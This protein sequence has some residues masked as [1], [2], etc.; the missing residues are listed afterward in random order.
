M[1]PGMPPGEAPAT[2][3]SATPA[4]SL[5]PAT[6]S[7]TSRAGLLTEGPLTGELDVLRARVAQLETQL[8]LSE[9]ERMPGS[10]S[11]GGPAPPLPPNRPASCPS[12]A[13][14]DPNSGEAYAMRELAEVRDRMAAVEG[15]LSRLLALAEPPGRPSAAECAFDGA[16]AQAGAPTAGTAGVLRGA[17]D[18]DELEVT[19]S[20]GSG[21]DSRCERQCGSPASCSSEAAAGWA[22]PAVAWGAQRA[23]AWLLPGVPQAGPLC[24]AAEEDTAS[25]SGDTAPLLKA[26]NTPPSP[27]RRSSQDTPG[28]SA[29]SAGVEFRSTEIEAEYGDKGV[30]SAAR[31]ALAAGLKNPFLRGSNN[32]LEKIKVGRPPWPP[33]LALAA[34]AALTF[35]SAAP[36]PAESGRRVNGASLAVADVQETPAEKGEAWWRCWVPDHLPAWLPAP[37]STCCLA[38]RAGNGVEDLRRC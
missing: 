23:G 15:M 17:A 18:L 13:S 29:P 32:L 33:P 31:N 5:R 10:S 35:P 34:A 6:S 20:M 37:D 22:R 12:A 4:E 30:R 1:R 2:A 21:R 25:T 3:C 8:T 16:A 24:E 14:V 19:P 27:L 9:G 26:Q 36:L 11:G 7:S 28:P 38:P